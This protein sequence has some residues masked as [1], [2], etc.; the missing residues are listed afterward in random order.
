[1]MDDHYDDGSLDDRGD[2]RLAV[3]GM[4]GRFPGAPDLESL[5]TLLVE[6]REGTTFFSDDTLRDAGVSASELR[7]P[8]YVKAAPVLGDVAA[9]DADF[10]GYTPR[11]AELLDPQ[12][13]LFLESAWEALEDAGWD[14]ESGRNSMGLFAG[15]GMS[16]YL[17]FNLRH[18]FTFSERGFE[19]L[20]GN[21][22]D[23]LSSRVAYKLDLGGPAVNVQ[24]ACSTSLAAVHLACQSLLAF[25]TDV[26]LAGGVTV[27]LPVTAGYAAQEGGLFSPDGHCRPFDAK[28]RGTIFG[29]GVGVVVLKRLADALRD[30]DRIRAVVLGSAVNNDGARKVG[31]TAPGEDGQVRL[32]SE[33]LELADVDPA[34][35]GYVE[36]HGTGTAL[37]DPIEVAALNR[38]FGDVPAGDHCALGSVKSNFGHLE[39]AAGIA[40]F[41]KAVLTVERGKI[42]PSLHFE[43]PNPHIAFDAGPFF[44]PRQLEEWRTGNGHR[45][46]GVSSFGIGGT[47]AHVL[48]ESAP[49]PNKPESVGAEP[50]SDTVDGPWI[51]PL[52]ARSERS[53]DALA[54]AYLERLRQPS[55]NVRD[56]CRS[57][58][59]R[60]A[61]HP[62]RLAAVGDDLDALRRSLGV[63][64]LGEG[65]PPARGSA[66]VEGRRRVVF[67]FPGQGSQWQGMG[68]RLME[69]EPVF[70]EALERCDRA[71]RAHTGDASTPG[72]SVID[73]LK[74]GGES[75]RFEAVEV[76]QPVLF[77]MAVALVE[78]WKSWGIEPD[79]VIGHSQGEIVGAYV[80]GALSLED[81]ARVVCARSAA[82][83]GLD[84]RGSMAVVDLG[85]HDAEAL[86]ADVGAA[87]QDV[88][89]V[90]VAASNSPRST[91]LTGD[92]A[93]LDAVA[94]ACGPRGVD[95]RRIKVAYASHSAAVDPILDDL[96]NT[97]RAVDARTPELTLYS[98]VDGEDS[99]R[100]HCDADYWARNLRR[101]VRFAEAV[102]DAWHD[103]HDLFLEVSPHPV[104]LHALKDCLRDLAGDARVG[105]GALS[106][107]GAKPQRQGHAVASLRRDEDERLDL[108]ENLAVLYAQGCAVDWPRAVGRPATPVPL[109]TYPWDHR[110][111]WVET[112]DTSETGMAGLVVPSQG[113]HP[114]LPGYVTLS[115]DPGTHLWQLEVSTERWPYLEQHSVQGQVVLP[116]AFY[117]ELA[118]AAAVQVHGDSVLGL[119]DVRFE[120]PLFLRGDASDDGDASHDGAAV[121]VQVVV[122][123]AGPEAWGFQIASRGDGE[124]RWTVH[125]T[126]GIERSTGEG[127]LDQ[128]FDGEPSVD[129][130]LL[131]AL[132]EPLSTEA[133]YAEREALGFVYGPAFRAPQELRRTASAGSPAS[134]GGPPNAGS[135]SAVARL[136][137]PALLQDAADYH[138]HP[139]VLDACFQV[140]AAAAPPDDGEEV[141]YLPASVGR[142]R[143]WTHGESARAP[144]ELWVHARLHAPT[145]DGR[146]ATPLGEVDVYDGAGRLVLRLEDFGFRRVDSQGAALDRELFYDLAWVPSQLVRSADEVSSGR[147]LILG[148]PQGLGDALFGALRSRGQACLRADPAALAESGAFGRLVERLGEGPRLRVVYLCDDAV[149][150]NDAADDATALAEWTMDRTEQ[151]FHLARAE[152]LAALDPPPALSIVTQGVWDIDTV[153]AAPTG[154]A[155]GSAFQ[156]G[157][158]PSDAF[159]S[160]AFQSGAFQSGAFRANAKQS[161]AFQSGAFQSGAFEAGAVADG[162][163]AGVNL[164]QSPVPALAAV[165]H[166]EH[167]DL[168]CRSID[169]P[170]FWDGDPLQDILLPELSHPDDETRVA[171]RD[172]QRFALR[173][174]P[175]DPARRQLRSRPIDEAGDFRLQ[176]G[177]PGRLE[178]LALH[179]TEPLA[180]S[181][182]TLLVEVEASSL[183]F[184]DVLSAMGALPRLPGDELPDPASTTLGAE[185]AGV[186]V[187]VGEGV[188][189]FEVG[190]AVVALAHPAFAKRVV[191]PV[192]LV[193]PK[194]DGLTFAQASCMAIGPMTAS[195]GLLRLAQLE[196]DEKVLIHSAA[197][198]TGLAAVAIAQSLG[199]EIFATAGTED[200]RDFLRSL[201]VQHVSDSRTLQF[202]DDFKAI[203]P[204]GVDVVLNSLSGDAMR[205]GL[206]LLAPYG[207]FVEIAKRDIYGDSQIG[208]SPFAKNISYFAV[209]LSRMMRE[210]PDR[211][212]RLLGDVLEMAATGELALPPIEHFPIS[213]ASEAFA[214]M[215]RAGHVGKIALLHRDPTASVV[216]PS[217]GLE[218]HPDGTYLV[219]GGLGGLGLVFA[220]H[221][222]RRGARHL[223]LLG[224]SQPSEH[225][226]LA[227]EAMESRGATVTVRAADVTNPRDMERIADELRTQGPPLRG[228]LHAAGT[229][230]DGLLATQTQERFRRVMAPKVTGAWLLHAMT[231]DPEGLGKDLDFFVLF[232][233]V[234]SINGTPGQSSYAAANAFLDA[235]AQHRHAEGLPVLSVNWGGWREVG[236]AAERFAGPGEELGLVPREGLAGLHE[237]LSHGAGPQVAL[238]PTPVPFWLGDAVAGSPIFGHFRAAEESRKGDGPLARTLRATEPSERQGLLEEF[239]VEQLAEVLRIPA[240]SMAVDVSLSE[241]GLTSLFALELR[242]RVETALGLPI[243]VLQFFQSPDLRA[244]GGWIL[245]RLTLV[246]L[247]ASPPPADDAAED[248]GEWEELTL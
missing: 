194:P 32:I 162:E 104:V 14:G 224:R 69:R 114:L 128:L 64:G 11:E 233:S 94:E 216:L 61:H 67:V 107:D 248:D 171:Y 213:R 177:E 137:V 209:D 193:S 23:Y 179:A 203:A 247:T 86:L 26:A 185:C 8:G 163:S 6:G 244:F 144:G 200:K 34:T 156:S 48:L 183:N 22:K 197:S 92:V 205:A 58:A 135:H 208:L 103:G 246:A 5:W 232:S 133:F 74:G 172:G 187:E 3:V 199:A 76:V 184:Y 10:F 72:W 148:N 214:L 123:P 106:R 152:A 75:Q 83:R 55:V 168:T 41:I 150:T 132:G 196:P 105:D 227:I 131:G 7:R 241:L 225:A 166:N 33:V 9:F 154:G 43:E 230:D 17:Y 71:I 136:E 50:G 226:R 140:L 4:A 89:A 228:V 25:E 30:G 91:V 78:L 95:F 161:G 221:L 240:E 49:E 73:T 147:W 174:L 36:A 44:V 119:R 130:G 19:S 151:L 235:L 51:L 54:E 178:T 53:L 158:F 215:A 65:A 77:A 24:T 204:D 21:D 207:R 96:R 141:V 195:Y 176:I 211:I 87:S 160:G 229:V 149:I 191:V 101:P 234:A 212:A 63:L 122:A 98:T 38:A 102:T 68:R 100:P 70:A 112:E 170:S 239:L 180:A 46:A 60:R 2:D 222:V 202:V 42:P 18:R 35:V 52:S 219:T 121:W 218:A 45:R 138:L 164:I 66:P 93:G 47:N 28:A 125:A 242:N 127:P 231:Q 116:A 111:Y 243:P 146:P 126:G 129:L 181:P 16:H 56:L 142:V 217:K 186:V 81:A 13:R 82:I 201:G 97:L 84:G 192:E 1:M 85:R 157:A 99:P 143:H 79:A 220:E 167:P 90:G 206:D 134:A 223:M 12:Q 80:A 115:V 165:I 110:R 113:S 37:G 182:G 40:G 173:L 175:H 27:R 59:T 188:E 236:M 29:S 57:A 120:T 108:L 124:R 210:R 153:R 39:C 139:A 31:Y 109:P 245:E 198:G 145:D 189:G 238:T 20:I 88:L 155:P 62:L 117:L 118:R 169:L 190:Q 15:C 237:L 159:Q